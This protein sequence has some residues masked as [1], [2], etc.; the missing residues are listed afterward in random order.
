[1]THRLKSVIG[2]V[3]REVHFYICGLSNPGDAAEVD[4]C[5]TVDEIGASEPR[6]G[7]RIIEFEPVATIQ[8]PRWKSRRLEHALFDVLR[9]PP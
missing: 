9:V 8:C 1:M 5:N 6:P 3:I 4:A 7:S 2:I